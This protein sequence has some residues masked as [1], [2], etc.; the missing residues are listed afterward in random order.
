MVQG[1]PSA[2]SGAVLVVTVLSLS[3]G[4]RRGELLWNTCV[5]SDSSYHCPLTLK[6]S[7][8]IRTKS[9]LLSLSLGCC[10]VGVVG[11]KDPW[12]RRVGRQVTPRPL[13]KGPASS[14]DTFRGPSAL[15]DVVR[16]PVM[17]L[18][19]GFL[20]G[21]SSL[22]RAPCLPFTFPQSSLQIHPRR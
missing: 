17:C 12:G 18:R 13:A 22:K 14:A 6:P 9:G 20:L 5:V 2:Q 4:G 19:V 16:L 15:A 21:L 7:T 10:P 3:L 1:L 11:A 8:G